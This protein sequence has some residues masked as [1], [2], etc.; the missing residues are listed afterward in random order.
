[1][2]IEET[3]VMVRQAAARL[4]SCYRARIVAESLTRG[5]DSGCVTCVSE[6]SWVEWIRDR[7][8]DP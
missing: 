4:Q 6:N 1:M 5:A 3:L 7:G 2:F 8:A